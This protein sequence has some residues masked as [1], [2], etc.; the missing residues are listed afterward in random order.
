MTSTEKKFKEIVADIFG[1]KVKDLK[2]S[3]K[4][5]EDLNA[6]SVDTIALIAAT[7]NEFGIKV[8]TEDARKNKTIKQT[9]TYINKRLKEKNKK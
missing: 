9:V 8:P 1:K 2:G 4:F 6:K 3:T 5:V 7:E